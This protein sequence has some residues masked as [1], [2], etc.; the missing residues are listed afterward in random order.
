[1]NKKLG[2]NEIVE[3]L[4]KE[5]RKLE[6]KLELEIM[7][8]E[9]ATIY[10]GSK[11]SVIVNPDSGRNF[12]NMEYFKVFHGDSFKK[13]NDLARI[14]FREPAYIKHDNQ[15]GKKD[16]RL[17]HKDKK[18]LNRIMH[19]PSQLYDNMTAWQDAIVQFNHEAYHIPQKECLKLTQK[20]LDSLPDSDPRKK[21]LPIDLPITDYSNL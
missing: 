1:M 3:E 2:I 13:A 9:M 4:D 19:T 10:A 12:Y 18:E 17:N 14:K 5:S 8:H 16:F 15:G 6:E 21:Y 20:F 11:L 7:L